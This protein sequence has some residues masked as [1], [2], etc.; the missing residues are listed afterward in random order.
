MR[1]AKN[2]ICTNLV[3]GKKETL[4]ITKAQQLETSEQLESPAIQV[5]VQR[6]VG[7]PETK[8]EIA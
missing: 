1:T 4:E 7:R 8:V 6:H 2:H 5:L 3:Q